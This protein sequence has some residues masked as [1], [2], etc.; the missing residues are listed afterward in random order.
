MSLIIFAVIPLMFISTSFVGSKVGKLTM[1]VE[2]LLSKTCA[3]TNEVFGSMRTVIAFNGQETELK[4]YKSVYQKSHKKNIENTFM[5]GCTMGLTFFF[6][7]SIYSLG[8]WYGAKLVRSGEI[9][10]ASVLKVFFTLMMGG[11]SIN[12]V[13]PS[14][15]VT[16]SAR[17]AA[18]KIFGIIEKKSKLSPIDN[19]GKRIELSGK[20][21]FKNVTFSYQS[22]PE[23]PALSNFSI[24]VK[25]GEKVALVGESGCGKST[26]VSLLQRLYDTDQGSIYVDDIDIKKLNIQTF[27]QQIGVVSQDPILFQTTIYNNLIYGAQNIQNGYPKMDDVVEACKKAQIYDFINSL[28]EKFDTVV[29]ERGS[30]QSGG[31]RQRLAIARALLR[32]PSILILDEATSALDTESEKLVQESIEKGFEGRTIIAVAHRLSTIKNYDKIYVCNKGSVVEQG[33]HTDLMKINGV[34]TS[35]VKAQEITGISNNPTAKKNSTIDEYHIYDKNNKHKTIRE[36]HGYNISSKKGIE[37]QRIHLEKHVL[38]DYEYESIKIDENTNKKQN[39]EVYEKRASYKHLF[40]LLKMN[41]SEMKLFTPGFLVTVADGSIF[42]ISSIALSRIFEALNEPNMEMQRRKTDMYAIFLVVLAIL[43][44]LTSTF[45]T[46]LFGIGGAKVSMKISFSMFKNLINQDLEYFDSSKNSPGALTTRLA[47]EPDDM[48]KLCV[49]AFPMVISSLSMFVIGI[50]IS[51]LNSW[52]LTLAVVATIPLI[53]YVQAKQSKSML[54]IL[55]RNRTEYEKSAQLVSE[56]ITNIK[57][58]VSLTREQLF[59]DRFTKIEKFATS[60]MIKGMFRYG[61]YKAFSQSNGHL[62]YSFSFYLGSKFIL[63]G[64]I[65]SEKMLG[66]LCAISFASMAFSQSSQAVSFLPKALVSAQKIVFALNQTPNITVK[67][68]CEASIEQSIDSVKFENVGFS[69]PTRPD[70]QILKNLNLN[71]PLGSKIGIVGSSGGGKS[72]ILSLILR[73]YDSRNGTLLIENNDIKNWPLSKLRNHSSLVS[74]DPVLFDL[75]ALENI[76]YGNQNSTQYDVEQAAKAANIHSLL[77]SLPD[78]YNTRVG[79]NG[80]QLSGGQKQRIA[81]AR[82]LLRNPKILLLDEATSSLDTENEAVVQEALD[83]ISETRTTITVAHRLSTIQNSDWI[84]VM[85]DQAIIEQGTHVSLLRL[86]GVYNNLAKKQ[87]L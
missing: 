58:V 80:G 22:R 3:I 5:V 29:G 34:Y 61:A 78:G 23:L 32:N 19:K 69:Y 37:T 56:S 83:K 72:T 10:A 87:F 2:R 53:F 39:Y 20:I 48:R 6:I 38:S 9:D 7:F 45:K 26:A 55:N 4:R 63:S 28:P 64:N 65:T 31:Q 21:N 75:S 25:P 1:E 81:I 42:P 52:M 76:K 16:F 66:S 44:F 71:V 73:L 70:V 27:R 36:D 77:V 57:T 8:F 43:S 40:E 85:R 17:G 60:L 51:L 35:L 54:G 12:G 18:T 68:D 15:S 74:Q 82:A 33:T 79:G 11:F 67:N 13:I 14:F 62:L 50:T 30:L 47:L 86:E 84:Y 46:Y 49:L 24:S 59:I 41:I